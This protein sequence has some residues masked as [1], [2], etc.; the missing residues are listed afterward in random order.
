MIKLKQ[1]LS[2]IIDK[3]WAKLNKKMVKIITPLALVVGLVALTSTIMTITIGPEIPL[4][5]G[6]ISLVI[7]RAGRLQ[8]RI[9]A[10]ILE[11]KLISPLNNLPHED[12]QDPSSPKK[13]TGDKK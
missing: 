11:A 6:T 2:N 3:I 9:D 5:L 4:I 13:S 8:Q 12:L 7:W 10:Q 1:K